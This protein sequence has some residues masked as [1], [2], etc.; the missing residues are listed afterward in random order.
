[1]IHKQILEIL[2]QYELDKD[3]PKM[4]RQMLLV[5]DGGDNYISLPDI[6]NKL[7]PITSLLHFIDNDDIDFAKTY[8]PNVKNSVNYLAGREVYE[9]D[10]E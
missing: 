7:T 8:L 5:F 2:E 3:Y 9:K 10:S 6:R 1:M 4:K